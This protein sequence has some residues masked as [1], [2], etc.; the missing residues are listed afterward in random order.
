MDFKSDNWFEN[1]QGSWSTKKSIYLIDNKIE[2]TYEE[3]FNL[4]KNNR[5][6]DD[7]NYKLKY[8]L[9]RKKDNMLFYQLSIIENLINKLKISYSIKLIEKNLIKFEHR[10]K[11]KSIIYSE[12]IYYINKNLNISI[13]FLKRNNKYLMIIFTSYIKTSNAL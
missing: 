4:E 2:H 1:L 12:Y 10:L 9:R 5:E 3:R 11:K 8:H 13:S 7:L 6:K